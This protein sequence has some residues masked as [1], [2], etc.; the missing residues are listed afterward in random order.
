MDT[1]LELLTDHALLIQIYSVEGSKERLLRMDNHRSKLLPFDYNMIYEPGKE[2][3]RNY[4]LSH[5]PAFKEY[6]QKEKED[7]AI[8]RDQRE[9]T[10]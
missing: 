8:F 4:G 6:T 2:C 3:P 10:G 7:W 9:Y 1:K 5:P